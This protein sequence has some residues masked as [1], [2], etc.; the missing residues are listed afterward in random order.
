[1]IAAARRL[2]L[3]RLGGALVA[4]VVLAGTLI[5]YLPGSRHALLR[6]FNEA[7]DF[8][9][10]NWLAFGMGQALIAASGVLPASVMA[11]MAGAA[12]GMAWGF[13]ISATFTMLGG[14]IAF[15]LARSLLRPFVEWLVGRTEWTQKF[16]A[17][18]EHEGWH[19]VLL[20]RLSPVMPF[21]LTSYGLGLTTIKQRDFLTGT[22][23]SLPALASFVALGAM[24]R[25][26]LTLSLGNG[27]PLQW[28]LFVIGLVAVALMIWRT[29]AIVKRISG[30][31]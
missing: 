13:V 21:A 9:A 24:G 26:G 3:L 2:G 7:Q 10:A 27:D 31:K 17:E 6:W 8:I 15:L 14:W 22:L 4:L 12:Y 20:L 11:V 16:D 29:G 18:L 28:A 5:A 25:Q 19:F 30:A 23:A 1:M